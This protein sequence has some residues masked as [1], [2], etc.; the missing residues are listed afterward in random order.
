MSAPQDT[1]A[2]VGGEGKYIAFLAGLNHRSLVSCGALSIIHVKIFFKVFFVPNSTLT[3]DY[4]HS[5]GIRH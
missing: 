1:I 4:G 2:T 5:P 3:I